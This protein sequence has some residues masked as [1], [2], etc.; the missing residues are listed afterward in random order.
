MTTAP[1]KKKYKK[2]NKEYWN[3]L[4]NKKKKADTEPVAQIAIAPKPQPV[5]NNGLVQVAI[6]VYD[7]LTKADKARVFAHILGKNQVTENQL[8]LIKKLVD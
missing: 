3:S 7:M 8:W 6:T 2:R 5:S 1:K 4:K